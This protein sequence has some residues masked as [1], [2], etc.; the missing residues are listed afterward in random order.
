M[1]HIEKNFALKNHNTMGISA[2]AE[3]CIR[4]TSN[5]QLEAFLK[6]DLS[7][8][9]ELLILGGGSNVLFLKDKYP[10][11]LLN[12]IGG[13]EIQDENED[14]VTL[15]V[16]SGVVWHDLVLFCIERNWGG[17]ENLSLIPGTVGAAPM[18]NIGAYGAEVKDVFVSLDALRKKD[19]QWRTFTNEQCQFGYRESVFKNI[20]KDEFVIASVTLK[21]SKNAVVNTSYGAISEQLKGNDINEPTIKDVSD[22]IIAIRQ[23]KL[24]DPKVIGN[25]GSFFKNPV[26]GSDT[27]AHLQDQNPDMPSYPQSDGKV[28]VPAGWLIE[29]A[30]WKGK[31]VGNIGVHNK[32]ALVLVNHDNGT[33]LEIKALSA[34]IQ[35]SIKEHFGIDLHTEV[36]F[37]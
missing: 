7:Q 28:K 26:I 12:E 20:H 19:Q 31:R 1:F 8:S 32:Q 37:V 11:V 6:D 30:G 10:I 33:G 16:G 36:N 18:Q 24:P 3:N 14:A 35:S 5:E 23:S 25:A 29:R 27:F 21:L 4:V 17:I 15:K 2:V 9:E 22:A 34:Q 13:I